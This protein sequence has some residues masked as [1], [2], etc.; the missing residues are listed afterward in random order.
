MSKPTWSRTSHHARSKVHLFVSDPISRTGWVSLC[1][2]HH[3]ARLNERADGQVCER[4]GSKQGR[5]D[6]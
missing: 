6:G 1:G 5:L 2:L 4:C 3:R